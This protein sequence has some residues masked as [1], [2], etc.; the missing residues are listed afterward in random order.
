MTG[1]DILG[2]PLPTWAVFVESLM[3]SKEAEK[4]V[5]DKLLHEFEIGRGNLRIFE[6]EDEIYVFEWQK[7][8]KGHRVH[9][10]GVVKA[11]VGEFLC[12]LEN[13]TGKIACQIYKNWG[14]LEKEAGLG[15]RYRIRTR[16][17]R[18]GK[19]LLPHVIGEGKLKLKRPRD[20]INMVYMHWRSRP[21][22]IL[23]GEDGG[24]AG[25]S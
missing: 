8:A 15:K 9:I 5:Q 24:G 17:K 19:E 1:C 23:E 22:E 4:I 3:A 25:A 2:T 13:E 21:P 7:E 16:I 6:R 14:E 12:G 20:V 10:P 11:A 18:L